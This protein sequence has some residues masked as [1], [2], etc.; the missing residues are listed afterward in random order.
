MSRSF[1]WIQ[2]QVTGDDD[3]D[4]CRQQ[5]PIVQPGQ[6][7]TFVAFGFFLPPERGQHTYTHKGSVEWNSC[8]GEQMLPPFRFVANETSQATPKAP[9]AVQPLLA[10]FSDQVDRSTSTLGADAHLQSPLGG[11][12][13]PL[14]SI[15]KRK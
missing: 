14:N 9:T 3:D 4:D 8:R 12:A 11:S 13:T 6:N 7:G 10:W 1:N 2:R 15:D 5:A